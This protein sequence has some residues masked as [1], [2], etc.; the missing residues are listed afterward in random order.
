M[1]IY[2]YIRTPCVSFVRVHKRFVRTSKKPNSHRLE[3]GLL[4]LFFSFPLRVQLHP[5]TGVALGPL[6]GKGLV[7][8]SCVLTGSF[9]LVPRAVT[10]IT[11]GA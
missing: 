3:V 4:L 7:C 8:F 5:N 6:P 2:N 9:L 1:C 10:L 11:S